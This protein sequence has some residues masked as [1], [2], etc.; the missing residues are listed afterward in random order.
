[1]KLGIGSYTYMWSIGFPGAVPENPL[2]AFGLLARAVELGVQVV[3]FGP[4]L[5]LSDL[6]DA[7]LGRVLAQAR[8]HGLQIELATRTLDFDHLR[9]QLS[10]AEKLECST[11]RT[12]PESVSGDVL[13]LSSIEESLRAI[14]PEVRRTPVRLTLENGRIPARR[15]A[16]LLDR[17]N[18]DRIGITLDT[19]NSLAIPEG[20]E[21]VAEAL[22]RWTCSLHLKDFVVMREWHMMG[23]RVEGRPAGKGQL[24]VPGLLELL[25]AA[26]AECNAILEL[27]PPQQASLSETVTLEHQWAKESVTYLRTLIK[28]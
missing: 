6:C 14:L 20:T 13:P 7:D 12:V 17:L 27:W 1:M 23:F 4:N 2:D 21:C 28:E 24:N 15:L 18:S 3:Q 10:L 11:L 25:F 5:P 8:Q 22:A 9:S 19:V 26:G 16:E